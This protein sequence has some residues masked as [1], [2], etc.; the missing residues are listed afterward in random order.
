[1][2][3]LNNVVK[4]FDTFKLGPL[5]QQFNRGKSY[6]I[7]GKSG[8]GKTTLINIIGM[9]EKQDSGEVVIMGHKNP[10]ISSKIGRGLLRHNISYMFQNYG[11]VDNESVRENLLLVNNK[12]LDLDVALKKVGLSGRE[13][14][15]I[16]T[17]SGGEQQRVAIAKILIK[18]SNIIIC[19]EPTGNLDDNTGNMIMDLL[20]NLMTEDKILIVVSH[21]MRHLSRFDE[22]IILG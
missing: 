3:E 5:N 8:S 1:M 17:L 9:L 7:T 14:Q 16:A 13:D 18:D 21:D 2:V 12:N 11:L 4:V 15:I 19:D 6:C 20:F 10:Q 22:H